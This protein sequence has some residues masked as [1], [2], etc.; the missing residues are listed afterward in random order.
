MSIICPVKDQ[1]WDRFSILY[2]SLI[3][4]LQIDH[5]IILVSP[6]G[7]NP[8]KDS[9][10]IRAFSDT[11]I[12]PELKNIKYNGVGW[13]KQQAIKLASCYHIRSDTVLV[14]DA[15]CIMVKDMCISD[16]I[17]NN[18]IKI[19]ISSGG[20]WDNWYYGSSKILNLD[21]NYQQNRIGVT[22]L[23]LSTNILH[24]LVSYLTTLY[25]SPWDY[26]LSNTSIFS[27]KFNPP[28]SPTWT[29]YCLYH[30]YGVNS[31]LWDNYHLN[32]DIELSGNS[33]WN[34]EE[35]DKW[36]ASKSFNNPDFYFTVAQSIAGKSI[37]WLK[38]RIQP[39]L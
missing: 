4:H 9:N 36:D 38:T 16:I 22:P 39:F 12:I 32:Y 15:D 10:K 20:S 25:E 8:Y 37:D 26:L 35:A 21:F 23:I 28:S 13:W 31:G 5:E 27:D 1:D 24:G 14:L 11:D 6:S 34:A 7:H 30:I 19:K 18:K 29:E 17:T 3:K 33:F 2:K